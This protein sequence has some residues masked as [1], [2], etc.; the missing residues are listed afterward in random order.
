MCNERMWICYVDRP[1]KMLRRSTALVAGMTS[2]CA[3]T[4]E[5]IIGSLNAPR[6]SQPQKAACAER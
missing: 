3:L 5:A 2:L 4:R 6:K 1:E